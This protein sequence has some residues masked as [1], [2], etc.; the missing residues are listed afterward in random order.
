MQEVYDQ[1][2]NEDPEMEESLNSSESE[3]KLT[4]NEEY[5]K[6]PSIAKLQLE[7]ITDKAVDKI[8]CE[9]QS[10]KPGNSIE[11]LFEELIHYYELDEIFEKDLSSSDKYEGVVNILK[12]REDHRKDL[13]SL[14]TELQTKIKEFEVICTDQNLKNSELEAELINKESEIDKLKSGKDKIAV[15]LEEYKI[16]YSDSARLHSENEVKY[17]ERIK[18][19]EDEVKNSSRLNFSCS[20]DSDSSYYNGLDSPEVAYNKLISNGEIMVPKAAG[21]YIQKLLKKISD[22]A[23]KTKKLRLQREKLKFR[24]ENEKK[25]SNLY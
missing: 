16:M 20:F 13:I 3:E 1:V 25:K 21:E 7:K 19:L 24:L 10:T 23:S 6:K 12:Q 18:E 8:S 9:K 5:S 11:Y 14:V 17:L 15:E 22:L 4:M 2:I